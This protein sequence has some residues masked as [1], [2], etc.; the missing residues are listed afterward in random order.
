MFTR[1][2]RGQQ[3]LPW[4]QQAG[5]K[6][7]SVATP[8]LR[9]GLIP[10]CVRRALRTWYCFC[11][12]FS[13]NCVTCCVYRWRR[14]PHASL[15]RPLSTFTKATLTT[16]IHPPFLL[17]PPVAFLFALLNPT[18]LSH[19]GILHADQAS[20]NRWPRQAVPFDSS[21]ANLTMK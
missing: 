18:I 4:L 21:S 5:S 16:L 1:M 13:C 11:N 15:A 20:S 10:I 12:A 2:C 9:I 7:Q 8:T 14:S 3:M 19:Q 6:Q 17:S